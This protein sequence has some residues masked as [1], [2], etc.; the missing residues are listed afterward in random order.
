MLDFDITPRM[1]E[2]EGLEKPFYDWEDDP[3]LA[4]GVVAA[5]A[6]VVEMRRPRPMP[7]PPIFPRPAHPSE[8]DIA[9]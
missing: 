2:E 9:A 5:I 8:E 6:T 7:S 4:S 1:D 3:E